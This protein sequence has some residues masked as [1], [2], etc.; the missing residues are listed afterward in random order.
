MITPHY[1]PSIIIATVI[2]GRRWRHTST[3]AAGASCSFRPA[4]HYQHTHIDMLW[5]P[6][7]RSASLKRSLL[8]QWCMN[9]PVT[10]CRRATKPSIVSARCS[11]SNLFIS[12]WKNEI[13]VQCVLNNNINIVWDLMF[14]LYCNTRIHNI[15]FIGLHICF[16]MVSKA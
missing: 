1:L 7:W 11:I 3:D 9:E 14:K 12:Q 13:I 16:L 8:G 10:M 5:R 4:K 6:I 15:L 2:V